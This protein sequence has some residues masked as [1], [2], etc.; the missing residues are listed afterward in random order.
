M[1][2]R[3][4]S[5]KHFKERRRGSIIVEEAINF[6]SV[7]DKEDLTRDPTRRERQQKYYRL[8]TQNQLNTNY[9]YYADKEKLHSIDN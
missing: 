6:Y 8:N 5:I 3:S 7:E 4:R 9:I 2:D 1:E